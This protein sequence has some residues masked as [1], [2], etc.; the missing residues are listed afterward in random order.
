MKA[1]LG[2]M[3]HM[4]VVNLPNLQDYLSRDPF[5]QS[6]GIWKHIMS[7]YRFL[8]FL[9][10]CHF[11]DK[12]NPESRLEKISPFPLIDHLN[13]TMSKIYCPDENLSL[14]ESTVQWRGRL[15][16]R[17]YM[18]NKRHKYGVKLYELCESTGIIFRKSIYSGVF[19]PAP[20]DLGQTGAIVMSLLTDFVNKGCTVWQLLHLR[21]TYPAI[22]LK[23]NLHLC[24]FTFRS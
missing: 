18:K 16:F 8:L 7:R 19:Y 22:K 1:F 4:G 11:Q 14:D 2:L 9:R 21:P 6:N 24:Y 17:Q 12:T 23:Q 13:N 5:L 15:I 20:Y 3:F 10:F